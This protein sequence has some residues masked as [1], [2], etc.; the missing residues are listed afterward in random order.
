MRTALTVALLLGSIATA[1]AGAGCDHCARHHR[2]HIESF[3]PQYRV[4]VPRPGGWY[5]RDIPS[6]SF[7]TSFYGEN[8]GTVH[9][10]N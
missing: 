10:G 2:S 6:D 4:I 9:Y 8:G 1:F 5:E 3:W 7:G